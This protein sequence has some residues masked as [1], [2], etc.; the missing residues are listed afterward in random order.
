MSLTAAILCL[1]TVWIGMGGPV[2][3]H[4]L[5][6][7]ELGAVGRA[8]QLATY[9]SEAAHE[10]NVRPALLAALVYLESSFRAQAVHRE[11]GAFGL[12]ALMPGSPWA[13]ALQADC[14]VLPERCEQ[15]SLLWSGRALADGIKACGSEAKGVG[16]YRTRRQCIAGPRVAHV[17]RTAERVDYLQT[18]PSRVALHSER[19]KPRK[20]HRGQYGRR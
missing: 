18:H 2:Y 13:T 10:A 8:Q 12:G 11:T 19:V 3:S 14:A 16:W 20:K 6:D 5:R 9:T 7:H 17:M 1:C 15:L 4:A